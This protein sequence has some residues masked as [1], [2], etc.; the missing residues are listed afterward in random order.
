M[1]IHH[2]SSVI[3]KTPEL[4]HSVRAL[5]FATANRGEEYTA[6]REIASWKN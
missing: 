3:V 5:D 6:Y 2:G 1:T 4:R